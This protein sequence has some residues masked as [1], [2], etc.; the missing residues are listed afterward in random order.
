MHSIIVATFLEISRTVVSTCSA[1][2]LLFLIALWAAKTD[3]AQAR[4]LDKIVA[5]SNLCFAVP[6]AVFGAL[7]FLGQGGEEAGEEVNG[8]WRRLRDPT[9]THT[10]GLLPLAIDFL[11]HQG[12]SIATE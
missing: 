4:G 6:L 10:I 9:A 11:K 8:C 2:I 5:L 7:H 12:G 1:G 3:I